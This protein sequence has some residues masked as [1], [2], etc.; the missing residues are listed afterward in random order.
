MQLKFYARPEHLQPWPMSHHY[1]QARRYIG[2][3]WIAPDPNVEGSVGRYE[4]NREGDVIDEE[5]V[6]LQHVIDVKKACAQGA[7]IAADEATAKACGVAYVEH[8]YGE[9]G[10]TPKPPAPEAKPEPAPAAAAPETESQAQSAPEAK[11][12]GKKPSAKE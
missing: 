6:P 7:L 1:G 11:P 8:V 5:R 12:A 9:A 10:F 4:P 3:R 2:W